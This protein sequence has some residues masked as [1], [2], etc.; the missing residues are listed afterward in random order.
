MNTVKD[1]LV[2]PNTNQNNKFD[3]MGKELLKL[4]AFS[5]LCG[6]VAYLLFILIKVFVN[7]D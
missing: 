1:N 2:N 4:L 7:T 3:N 6:S 5:I